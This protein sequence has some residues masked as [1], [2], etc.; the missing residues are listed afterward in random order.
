[1]A[2]KK[3]KKPATPRRKT[4][5]PTAAPLAAWPEPSSLTVITQGTESRMRERVKDAYGKEF[6]D[7]CSPEVAKVLGATAARGAAAGA[8]EEFLG[9]AQGPQGPRAMVL[10]FA[11]PEVTTGVPAIREALAGEAMLGGM[12]P[13]HREALR[14][15]AR[16]VG[17]NAHRDS[18]LKTVAGVCSHLEQTARRAFGAMRE[19]LGAPSS[20]VSVVEVCWLNSTVRSRVPPRML[21]EVAAERNLQRIDM[22]RRLVR[23]LNLSAVTVGGPV[24]RTNFNQ[25]G[26][27]VVVAVIDSEVDITHPA[28]ADRVIQAKDF[29]VE[30]FGKPDTHGTGVAGIIGGKHK[31]F[32]GIAPGVTIR[33]YKV[34]ATDP[35][36]DTDDFGGTMAIQTALEDGAQVANLSW[37]VGPVRAEKSRE[38]RACDTA[39]ANGLILVKSA[40]NSG[41]GAATITSP[42]DADGII[43]VGATDRKGKRVQDYSSRG[44][45][46]GK[47][48]PHL[49]APGGTMTDGIRTCLPGGDFGSHTG[50]SFAAP[51]VTGLVALLLGREPDATPDRIRELLIG[52]CTVFNVNDKFTFGAGLV[53]LARIT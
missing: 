23:E 36:H 20:G 49:V 44:D 25:S 52:Q 29:T 9:A 47:P 43:V 11:P 7:K 40:G 48:R 22:P 45:T 5:N 16:H 28:L 4:A 33:N 50:T 24:F 3:R 27:D 8:R 12:A 18:T 39:W 2:T 21:A 10:E 26:Q 13:A 37:G 1:M 42:A 31:K 53:S 41:P 19:G 32:S 38:A 14:V 30:G 17:I 15:G 34:L 51:H 46:Q 35:A 6:A